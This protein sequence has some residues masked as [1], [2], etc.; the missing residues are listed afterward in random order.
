MPYTV[1]ICELA[2]GIACYPDGRRYLV[3]DGPR[4]DP[5]FG[6][7]AEAEAYSRET[8]ARRPDLECWVIDPAGVVLFRVPPLPI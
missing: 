1:R 6:T 3:T 7:L 2:T 8:I 5:D 4:H